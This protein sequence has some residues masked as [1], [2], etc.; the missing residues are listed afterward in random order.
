[1][2]T[3][4]AAST[5][6]TPAAIET[7]ARWL[8]WAMARPEKPVTVTTM[9]DSDSITCVRK[10]STPSC[11]STISNALTESPR[12]SSRMRCASSSRFEGIPDN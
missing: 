8:V 9:P 2:A 11:R 3:A 10:T 4:A 12:V 6:K 7:R 1:M 5:T